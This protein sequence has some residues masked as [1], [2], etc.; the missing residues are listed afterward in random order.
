MS[1]CRI[2][3]QWANPKTVQTDIRHGTFELAAGKVE[4]TYEE[5]GTRVLLVGPANYYVDSSNS[6][7]LLDGL[8]FVY[9]LERP[10]AKTILEHPL[11]HV[12]TPT[13]LVT[14]GGGSEFGSAWTRPR[15]ATWPFFAAEPTFNWRAGKQRRALQ[16]SRL[17]LREAPAEPR[18]PGA[19][20]RRGG[21]G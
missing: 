17:D 14:D 2:D 20:S 10:D 5:T 6:G 13:V 3:P 9:F 16:A 7:A 15:R 1:L 12:R 21:K 18:P 11:F 19:R 8:V 4:I